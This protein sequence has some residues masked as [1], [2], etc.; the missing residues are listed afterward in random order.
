M[1]NFAFLF[2]LITLV[3][4]LA[5]VSFGQQPDN[6]LIKQAPG[7]DSDY[8]CVNMV[9]AVNYLRG[10][11][12]AKA[13]DALHNYFKENVGRGDE[14]EKIILICRLLFVNP[15][16]WQIP[17]LGTPDPPVTTNGMAHF[18]IFPL[19]LSDGVPFLLVHGYSG[20]GMFDNPL[21]ELRLCERLS[22]ITND[23]SQ[24]NYAGACR[25]LIANTNFTQLYTERGSDIMSNI[26]Y[27]QAEK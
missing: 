17:M 3:L 22:I 21:D 6:N 23:L 2:S 25:D 4:I 13:L 9:R 15:N 10:L 8:H 18:P 11:G 24:T 26:I 14:Q 7:I 20:D 1:K 12:K 5:F 27:Q 19:A 16:G